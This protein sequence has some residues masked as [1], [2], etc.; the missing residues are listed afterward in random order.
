M[1]VLH[2]FRSIASAIF[3]LFL[4]F[5]IVPDHQAGANEATTKYWSV[6]A[7]PKEDVKIRVGLIQQDIDLYEMDAIYLPARP[8]AAESSTAR[9]L[10]EKLRA[11]YQIKL[12][13]ETKLPRKTK[14]GIFVGRGPAV[15]SSMIT[16]DELDAVKYDGYVIKGSRNRVVLAGYGPQGTIYAGYDFLK[17]IG[18]K[19]YPWHYSGGLETFTPVENGIIKPFSIARAPFFNYRGLFYSLDRGPFGGS[20]IKY[21]LGDFRF[22]LNYENFKNNGWLSWDHSAG[23]LVPIQLYFDNHPEYFSLQKG[24]RISKSTPNLRVTLCMCN[25]DVVEISTERALD[26][27]DRQKERRYFAITDGDAVS[28]CIPCESADPIPD[29]TTDRLLR[30]VNAVARSVRKKYPEKIILSSAYQKSIKTPIDTGLESNVLVMYSP[31][32]WSS[33]TTSAVSFAHPLN[34]IAMEELMGWVM[35]FPNQ[36]GVYEY[37]QNWVFGA[38][39]RIKFYAKNNVRWVHFNAPQGNLMHWIISRLLWDPFLD[40]A[41]LEEEFVNVFYGP[42]A[43]VMKKYLELRRQTIRHQSF[44]TTFFFRNQDY[45]EKAKRLL[46]EAEEIA[47]RSSLG[48]Q[49]RILE[50]VTEGLYTL[51]KNHLAI[52]PSHDLPRDDYQ[53]YVRLQQ[54]IVDN[55]EQLKFSEHAIRRRVHFVKKQLEGLG[56]KINANT[57]KGTSREDLRKVFTDA[58]ARFKDLRNKLDPIVDTYPSVPRKRCT[59]LSFGSQGEQK[60]WRTSGSQ[61]NLVSAPAAIRI[62]GP[63]SPLSGIRISAPLS[64]LPVLPR[65]NQRVHAGRFFAERRFDAPLEIGGCPFVDFHL[66]ASGDAPVTVYIND[67]RSDIHLHAGE[68]IVRVDLRNHDGRGRF[69]YSSW[70]KKIKTIAIDIWPQDNFYPYPKVRDIDLT[71]LGMETKNYAPVPAL[72]PYT[73]K[74]IWLSQFRP[75]LPFK[76]VIADISARQ[77]QLQRATGENHRSITH[78]Y[79][80]R[81]GHERYRTFTEHRIISPI[82]AIIAHEAGPGGDLQAANVLQRSLADMYGVTLPVNPEG[83]TL[84]PNVG[85]VAIVGSAAA[86]RSGRIKQLALDHAG[87]EGY[88]IR[89]RDGRIIIAG[90][91]DTG[92]LVGVTRYLADHGAIISGGA[93]QKWFPDNTNSFLHELYLVD[94]PYFQNPE[95]PCNLPPRKQ[96]TALSDEW[97]GP[98]DTDTV[99]HAET[100]ARTIKGIAR[101]GEQVLDQHILDDAAR[102]PLSCYVAGKLAWNPFED[103]GSLI[104]E[105]RES[106]GAVPGP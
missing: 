104:T 71:V 81:R 102:S 60:K 48:T 47:E 12:K 25:P 11:L 33:R 7:A 43:D 76:Y 63:I 83:V 37:P 35:R 44:H 87:R 77:E 6:R 19:I 94:K 85:N 23:Y 14:G 16:E 1:S 99:S 97:W 45:L 105:F 62:D 3:F 41:D 84:G 55:G 90:G 75:N 27:I 36:I 56:V 61:Q 93:D 46:I 50:G 4:C 70:D 20:I 92:V 49:T 67:L 29:Y 69:R 13:I 39:E 18:L 95:I 31:W 54:R 91:K 26:W 40:T 103:T 57:A 42:A 79:I 96:P 72:L 86:L 30:W 89:A 9:L 74:A 59:E 2:N 64:R 32:Y 80:R 21:S 52:R 51:L 58:A 24:R 65:V 106:L 88:L 17:R 5:V 53:R 78:T 66:Y 15:A 10:Q 22:A 38:A 68:Q 100:I 8:S 101:R 73:G 34:L 98:L 82:A 28:K